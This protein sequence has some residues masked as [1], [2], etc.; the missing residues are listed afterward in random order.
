MRP[1]G[2]AGD[3]PGSPALLEGSL[4]GPRGCSRSPSC[5]LMGP[6]DPPWLLWVLDPFSFSCVWRNPSGL[7]RMALGMLNRLGPA[8]QVLLDAH[9]QCEF[10]A[11][12]LGVGL[13][14][15]LTHPAR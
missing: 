11:F 5:P 6:L 4:R 10:S 7:T 3:S 15:S 1:W 2:S 12:S 14:V 13:S 9:C 8:L